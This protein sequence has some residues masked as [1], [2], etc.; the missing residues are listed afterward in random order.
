MLCDQ[1]PPPGSHPRY[2][3]RRTL[4]SLALT[5]S[6]FP[7]WFKYST[8]IPQ[9]GEGRGCPPGVQNIEI[10][11]ETP[12][13][14]PRLSDASL[15]I[16]QSAFDDP[17]FGLPGESRGFARRTSF[18]RLAPQLAAS[19]QSRISPHLLAKTYS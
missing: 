4:P 10:A 3:A 7:Y 15:G 8:A 2:L 11:Q 18:A 9:V 17:M 1:V 14:S 5:W 16:K 12:T 6:R 19:C 13:R